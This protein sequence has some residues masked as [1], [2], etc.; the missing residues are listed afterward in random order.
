MSQTSSVTFTTSSGRGGLAIHSKLKNKHYSETCKVL[1]GSRMSWNVKPL[2]DNTRNLVQIHCKFTLYNSTNY[3][4]TIKNSAENS[5]NFLVGSFFF[6]LRHCRR[7]YTKF[8]KK[9]KWIP[10][11]WLGLVRNCRILVLTISSKTD[12]KCASLI[13]F[14]KFNS[15]KSF[16]QTAR[17]NKKKWETE[18]NVTY[19]NSFLHC[20]VCSHLQ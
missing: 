15:W 17:R 10:S 4:I 13:F 3:V 20:V 16:C 8:A 2:V 18:K 11:T 12:M 5:N 1:F 6:A 19:Q 9:F 7:F 14:C